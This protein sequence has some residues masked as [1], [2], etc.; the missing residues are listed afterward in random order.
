MGKWSRQSE[1]GQICRK[2]SLNFNVLVMQME[3]RK[4]ASAPAKL[5]FTSVQQTHETTGILDE[6]I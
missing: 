5:Q 6:N 4:K 1:Q 3:S 2:C